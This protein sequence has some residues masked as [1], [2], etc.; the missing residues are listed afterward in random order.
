MYRDN[1]QIL[2]QENI[3]IM[4]IIKDRFVNGFLKILNYRPVDESFDTWA[5]AGQSF[6]TGHTT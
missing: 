6:P 4:W 1:H 2:K 5:G 3:S